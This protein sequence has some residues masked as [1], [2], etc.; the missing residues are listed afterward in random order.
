MHARE[1]TGKDPCVGATSQ[2]ADLHQTYQMPTIHEEGMDSIM[3]SDAASLS[4]SVP[5]D[6]FVVRP[7]EWPEH[8]EA[9]GL[10]RLRSSLNQVQTLNALCSVKH[11]RLTLRVESS[12]DA[13]ICEDSLVTSLSVSNVELTILPEFKDLFVL[14]STFLHNDDIYCTAADQ[15]SRNKWVAVFRRCG[16]I[17]FA[18][19]QTGRRLVEPGFISRRTMSI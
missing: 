4:R 14:S 6:H 2:C 7:R 3:E 10:L 19:T 1:Q 11:G 5:Q 13:G 17:I 8:R 18:G 15:T 16:I 9:W 12:L